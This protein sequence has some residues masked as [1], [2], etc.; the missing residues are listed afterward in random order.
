MKERFKLPEEVH[1]LS[2][3]IAQQCHPLA[4]EQLQRQAAGGKRRS[5]GPGRWLEQFAGCAKGRLPLRLG[6]CLLGRF[7]SGSFFSGFFFSS[8]LGGGIVGRG[9]RRGG[10]SGCGGPVGQPCAPRQADAGEQGDSQ[11]LPSTHLRSTAHGNSSQA[12]FDLPRLATGG[13]QVA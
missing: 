7:L 1:P 5:G 8:S 4:I 13:V 12:V 6:R 3:R 2:G 9:G 11:L 10:I